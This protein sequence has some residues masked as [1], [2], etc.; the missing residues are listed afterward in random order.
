MIAQ[1][2]FFAQ[3]CSATKGKN[4]TFFCINCATVLRMETLKQMKYF[5]VPLDHAWKVQVLQE[6]LN[7]KTNNLYVEGFDDFVI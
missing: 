4:C 7:T 1:S 6:L 5:N 2:A 3:K